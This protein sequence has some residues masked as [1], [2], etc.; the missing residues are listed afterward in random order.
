MKSYILILFM[1]QHQIFAKAQESIIKHADSDIHG[2]ACGPFTM[3]F[4][5]SHAS[6]EV[7]E[8]SVKES[9]A[10][11]ILAPDAGI[12]L[13]KQLNQMMGIAEPT[14]V[15]LEKKMTVEEQL[16][17]AV[18]TQDFE[19]AAVLRDRLAPKK[20]VKRRIKKTEE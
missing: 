12:N 3:I 11:Y 7:I 9:G 19:L 4:F 16:A 18:E 17:E 20:V 8:G 1:E 5:K 6:M 13:P 15:D 14:P 2:I 10:K